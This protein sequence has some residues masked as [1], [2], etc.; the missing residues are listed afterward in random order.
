[1]PAEHIATVNAFGNSNQIKD[2]HYE[3]HDPH[4][5]YSFYRLVEVDVDGETHYTEW[6]QV[7][8]SPDLGSWN[9]RLFPN[10]SQGTFNLVAV[11]QGNEFQYKVLDLNGKTLLRKHI[12]TQSGAKIEQQLELGDFTSG[13]YILQIQNGSRQEVRK[14]IKE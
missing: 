5:G 4:L 1:M 12:L 10:P 13:I 9:L 11:A 6:Q 3:D 14:L 7:N 2:Y 8:F